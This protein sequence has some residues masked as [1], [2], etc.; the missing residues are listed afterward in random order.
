MNLNV[1][2]DLLTHIWHFLINIAAV[3][4]LLRYL[5]NS[6]QQTDRQE[7]GERRGAEAVLTAVILNGLEWST[8]HTCCSLRAGLTEQRAAHAA[9]MLMIYFWRTHKGSPA[10]APAPAPA[11]VEISGA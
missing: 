10:P 9:S 3:K 4:Y 8:A 2:N 7:A 1:P 5:C 6:Q 11:P